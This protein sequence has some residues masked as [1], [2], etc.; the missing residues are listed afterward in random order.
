MGVLSFSYLFL[1]VAVSVFIQ[2]A[3]HGA[4]ELELRDGATPVRVDELENGQQRFLRSRA[5]AGAACGR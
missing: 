1:T 2:G 3:V 5:F 4:N